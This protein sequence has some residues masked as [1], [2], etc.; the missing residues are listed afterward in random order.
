MY[1]RTNCINE[2]LLGDSKHSDVNL[3]GDCSFPKIYEDL[4]LNFIVPDQ[5]AP[6]FS[7]NISSV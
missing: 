1:G 2:V 6:L 4:D 7:V 5:E 3:K